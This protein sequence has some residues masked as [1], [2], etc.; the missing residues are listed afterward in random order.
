MASADDQPQPST[1]KAPAVDDNLR[2]REVG[3]NIILDAEKFCATINDPQGTC[4]GAIGDCNLVNQIVYPRST[5]D[6]K[7]FHITC[8]IDQSLQSKIEKGE[9]V[10]LEKLLPRDPT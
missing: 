6:D 4:M 2:A 5:I 10:D 3:D 1:S 8:H 9:F 7:F